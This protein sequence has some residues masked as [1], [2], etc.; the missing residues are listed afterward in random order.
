MLAVWFWKKYVNRPLHLFG[1]V[2][3]GLI[4]IS[5]ISGLVA[6]YHKIFNGQDLS[7]TAL[8][9]LAI[10]GFM[11]GIQFFVFGLIADMLSKNY[12]TI[13][14]ERAYTIKEIIEQ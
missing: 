11:F 12:H 5:I 13:R 6:V 3:L 8:T 9:M 14:K 2:G 1:T 4:F 10:I 7:E